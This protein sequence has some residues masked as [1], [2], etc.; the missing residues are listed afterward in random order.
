MS[1]QQDHDEALKQRREQW[2]NSGQSRPAFAFMPKRDQE[3]VW[4]YPRPPAI[5]ENYKPIL[6]KADEQEI[7][8]S[9]AGFRV[10]ETAGAPT[11][12]L[13]PDDVRM[14]ALVAIEQ[15]SFCEWKGEAR[16]WALA[17]DPEQRAVAWAYPD[18][19]DAF[20]PIAHCLSF[21]PTHLQC[22]LNGER[23]APQ[24]GG[25]YGGWVTSTIVGPFKGEPGTENW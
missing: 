14:T 5:E 11:Y 20:L 2:H 15:R 3:S 24:P 10:L 21:Y 18:P 4:D 8:R 1:N 16:Y 13:P 22:W 23:V 19:F 12:Y 17:G 7:A 25:F 6:V 9:C